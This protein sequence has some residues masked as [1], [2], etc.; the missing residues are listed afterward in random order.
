MRI[1]LA[2]ASGAVGRALVPL[3]VRE[4]HEVTGMT[5][6]AA[7]ADRIRAMGAAASVADVFDRKMLFRIVREA[8]PDVVL[9]QLTSLGARNFA[10]NARIRVDG[11]RNLV[12]AAREAGVRR[13]VAQ[14]IAWAAM[15]GEGPATEAEPLDLGAVQ[16]R[17][18]T[19][20]GVQALEQAAAEMPEAVALRYGLFY[21][22]GTWYAP[23]GLM[24][25]QARNGELP[26]TDGVASFIHVDDAARAAVLALT[27]PIGTYHIVD[28]E[29]APGTA[30][31]PAFA[32]AVGA[33][34]P[35][36][37]AGAAPWE[38]GASNAKARR[39]LGWAPRYASWREGFRTL[40]GR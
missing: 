25:E 26:A 32:A 29:P 15:P 8:K 18:G 4:G 17:L 13:M 20:Q 33:P 5:R 23:D 22:P 36:V 27:W 31:V 19:V 3:L 6:D 34:E 35:P 10:D 12:D 39:E 16:P 38:R 9:H 14:S 37:R 21:G 11:T 2:G 28:D 30:W 7:H 24:A 40:G 1:F